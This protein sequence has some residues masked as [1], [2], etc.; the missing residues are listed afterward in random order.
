[1]TKFLPL[2]AA[3]L[4][5]AA[6]GRAQVYETVIDTKTA[7]QIEANTAAAA[8]PENTYLDYNKDML[9]SSTGITAASLSKL[10]NYSLD[11]SQ[12]K[13]LFGFTKDGAMY[14][15]LVREVTMLLKECKDCA[16]TAA[17]NPLMVSD[18]REGIIRTLLQAKGLVKECVV[19]AFNCK[20]P[21][22]FKVD[23]KKLE[24]GKDNTKNYAEDS[25]RDEKKDEDGNNLLLPDE[26]IRIIENCI[27]R[28]R[29][30]RRSV[31]YVNL[32]MET[33]YNVR[34]HLQRT[35]AYSQLLNSSSAYAL[36]Q[37]KRDIGN[38]DLW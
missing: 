10:I 27:S 7:A 2:I 33:H 1:M 28:L 3:G 21:N 13:D 8:V 26:R 19:V 30:L 32:K 22:P 35:P 15:T 9:K 23:L 4:L 25:S 11:M 24:E 31:R 37:V 6:S 18:C 5:A 14:H 12:R 16:D 17:D 34:Y 38:L 36:R 20:V 29:E